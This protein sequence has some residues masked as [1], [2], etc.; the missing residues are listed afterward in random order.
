M[1]SYRDYQL[2]QSTIDY[3]KEKN[4]RQSIAKYIEEHG[5]EPSDINQFFVVSPAQI[6]QY[7]RVS[8]AKLLTSGKDPESQEDEQGELVTRSFGIS[9]VDD[10]ILG[11]NGEILRAGNDNYQYNYWRIIVKTTSKFGNNGMF[12]SFYAIGDFDSL[13]NVSIMLDTRYYY[14]FF[15]YLRKS[16]MLYNYMN[17]GDIYV[18]NPGIDNVFKY[19]ISSDLAAS[20]NAQTSFGASNTPQIL[21]SYW[22]AGYGTQYEKDSSILIPGQETNAEYMGIIGKYD[23]LS[24]NKIVGKVYTL[25]PRLKCTFNN[26]TKD[27]GKLTLKNWW[28]SMCTVNFWY[29]ENNIETDGSGEII[30]QTSTSFEYIFPKQEIFSLYDTVYAGHFAYNGIYENSDLSKTNE[31]ITPSTHDKYYDYRYNF[32]VHLTKE[33]YIPNTMNGITYVI[34]RNDMSEISINLPTL[35]VATNS[36]IEIEI[37]ED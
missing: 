27:S 36:D 10:N 22:P 2:P 19:N 24:G 6:E 31:M 18:E 21:F 7:K 26:F 25:N 8:Y 30:N 28:G 13:R 29:N 4:A 20:Y 3:L 34:Y 5:E 23:P 15:I 37:V 11:A 35:E 32:E 12:A 1:I 17:T 14:T 16:N 33:G 9:A